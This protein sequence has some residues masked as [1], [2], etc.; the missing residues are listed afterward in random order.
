MG[1][2]I[3]ADAVPPGLR[4]LSV[5]RHQLAALIRWLDPFKGDQ[6]ALPRSPEWS[7]LL[8]EPHVGGAHASALADRAD[9]H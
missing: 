1:R 6:T 2:Q 3:P 8:R 9:R 7:V 4:C 5:C